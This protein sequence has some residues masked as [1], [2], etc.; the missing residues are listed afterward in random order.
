MAL[1]VINTEGISDNV[2][3]S[4]YLVRRLPGTVSFDHVHEL[5]KPPEG[6]LPQRTSKRE[7]QDDMHRRNNGSENNVN[8]V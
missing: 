8:M 2:R 6:A 5:M 3:W 4:S 7:L 1:K